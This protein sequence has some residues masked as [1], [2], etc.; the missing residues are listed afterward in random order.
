MNYF[1]HIKFKSITNIVLSYLL[2]KSCWQLKI[3]QSIKS[4]YQ[5]FFICLIFIITFPLSDN[6]QYNYKPLKIRL[7][8]DNNTK[9]I[10]LPLI[11]YDLRITW[12][13]GNINT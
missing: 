7:L 9:Q 4:Y 1:N 13:D 11:G 3:Q 5:L 2:T 8:A 12:G 10:A 6:A